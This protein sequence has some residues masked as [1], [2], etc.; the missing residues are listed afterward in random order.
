[1]FRTGEARNGD[2]ATAAERAFRRIAR[3]K[4]LERGIAETEVEAKI[5]QLLARGADLSLDALESDEPHH[6]QP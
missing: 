5:S 1:M 4:L 2:G 6:S 3:R